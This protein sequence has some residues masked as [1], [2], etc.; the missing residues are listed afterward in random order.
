M[1]WSFRDTLVVHLP[2]TRLLSHTQ[3]FN[4]VLPKSLI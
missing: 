4:D 3:A 2:D 1:R